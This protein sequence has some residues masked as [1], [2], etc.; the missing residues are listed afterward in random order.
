[1][2][3]NHIA[4]VNV[5][6][7]LIKAITLFPRTREVHHCGTIFRTSPFDIDATCPACGLFRP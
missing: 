2:T 3:P 7:D 5:S 6:H 1:M 4:A